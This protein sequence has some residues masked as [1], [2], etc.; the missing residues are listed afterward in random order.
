MRESIVGGILYMILF[1]G[2]IFLLA[3]MVGCTTTNY[4]FPEGK[5][6]YQCKSTIFEPFDISDC[7]LIRYE[8]FK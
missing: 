8:K 4:K 6:Y 1:F 2:T 7:R 3:S 5:Y